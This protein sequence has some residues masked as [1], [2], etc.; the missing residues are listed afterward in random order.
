M[1]TGVR[2]RSSRMTGICMVMIAMLM[3]AVLSPATGISAREGPVATAEAG[4]SL[5]TV[6]VD[7]DAL[8]DL[9]SAGETLPKEPET[10]VN[11]EFGYTIDYTAPWIDNGKRTGVGFTSEVL[12]DQ[13][14][15]ALMTITP[16]AWEG[17]PAEDIIAWWASPQ[18]T[19][20]WLPGSRVLLFTSRDAGGAVVRLGPE[21]AGEP[22]RIVYVT[23]LHLFD[24]YALEITYSMPHSAFG[25]PYGSVADQVRL[26]GV[27]AVGLFDAAV[28]ES[29]LPGA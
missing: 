2:R 17:T 19:D 16:Y 20:E 5:S 12:V 29:E 28:I 1:V 27:P 26:N 23:E 24:G 22:G 25:E 13:H 15:A 10:I 14:N 7:V 11:R 4:T 21:E 3:A 6:D 9:L 8:R 18:A